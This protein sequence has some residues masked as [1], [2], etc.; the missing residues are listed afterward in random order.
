MKAK[1]SKIVEIQNGYQFRGK[2]EPVDLPAADGP[3]PVLPPGV[4]RVIQIKDFDDD[5]R[6]Q[7]SGLV[8]VRIDADPEKYETREGDVLFLARG[9]R[10]FAAAI[11]EPLR[12]TVATGYF[13]ILRLKTDSIRAG[14]L[15]WYINQPPFQSV[16]RT[17]MK[18]THQPLVSRKDI[19]DLQVEIPPLAT[20]ETVVALDDL[21]VREHQL[22]LTLQEKRTQLL[23]TISMKAVRRPS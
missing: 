12:D 6:L 4:V 7:S 11:T 21:R 15:A 19:E 5:R 3:R 16:L 9:H 20:Q 1:L 2:V 10:L 22:M 8:S 17:F 23:Q 18:G 14:Y 13:F